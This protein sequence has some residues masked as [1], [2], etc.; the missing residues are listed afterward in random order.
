MLF[1][2]QIIICIY[3]VYSHIQMQ[4]L[5]FLWKLSYMT[6]KNEYKKKLVFH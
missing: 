6:N 1:I 4:I 3:I 5:T 2:L